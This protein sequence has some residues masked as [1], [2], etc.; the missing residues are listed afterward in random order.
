MNFIQ[1]KLYSWL[2][3]KISAAM[4]AQW[5]GKGV[6]SWSGQNKQS[7]VN[8]GYRAN[9]IVY[10][11]INLVTEKAKVAPWAEYEVVDEKKYLQLKSML[12]RPDLVDDWGA[13]ERMQKSALEMV[14]K[15]S[16]IG[17]LLK[18]PNETETWSAL[19]KA[20]ISYKLIT[21][22]AYLFGRIIE[23]GE[24]K[25]VPN[26]LHILPSQYMS[27]IANIDDVIKTVVG[28]QLQVNTITTFEEYEILHD[29]SFNPNWDGIGSELYGMSPLEAGA[30]VLTR[31]NEG[32]NYA[33]ATLQNGGPTGVL[34]VKKDQGFEGAD[35]SAQVEL[36]KQ[37][38]KQYEGSRN[39]NKMPVSGLEV[40][41]QPVGLSPVDMAI[42]EAELFDMRAICNI[43]GIPSQLLN[44]TAAK[45]YN[46]TT[47]AEK[48]L[49]VRG[50][51]PQ[52]TSM[53]DALNHKLYKGWAGKNRRRVVDFD[54]SAFP[55]LQKNKKELMEW[56]S[57]APIS[58]ERTLEL[59]GE[60]VPDW[61]D[62]ETRRTILMP[63]TMQA[64]GEMP[65]DLP[66]GQNPYGE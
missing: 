54:M 55:E 12:S 19:V 27:I 2:G 39:A 35:L 36:I 57:K 43:Y 1:R 4:T 37:R 47:E 25:G 29:K 32:K 10:S 21:G 66:P 24:N 31:S 20:F 17:E 60:P 23:L 44:D 63:S 50:A 30:R 45:T 8:D 13:V 28:Y 7:M 62:E 18:Y 38:L 42:L 15:P 33:V 53:R 59:L 64:L 51:L 65:I 61:M 14:S 56:I 40:G 5:V 11:C 58:I 3:A 41:Y 34:Y 9:D 16:K 48:S 46:T 22:D 52:L 49:T 6:V 26:S